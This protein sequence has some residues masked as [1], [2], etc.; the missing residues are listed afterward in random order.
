MIVDRRGREP[1]V[2]GERS[3]DL[4]RSAILSLLSSTGA[5]AE[6][7]VVEWEGPSPASAEVVVMCVLA[8][9]PTCISSALDG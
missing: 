3:D 7:S 4:D 8:F 9:G 1:L 2:F 5:S 6:L